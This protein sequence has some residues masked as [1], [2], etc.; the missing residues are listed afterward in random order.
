[1]VLAGI[2][3]TAWR[4]PDGTPCLVAARTGAAWPCAAADGY[5]H[6]P[7]GED[8]GPFAPPAPALSGPHTTAFVDG[9]VRAR[10]AD[11][12]ENILDTT[13]TSVVHQ[14]YLRR[15]ADRRPVEAHTASGPGWIAAT[16]PPGA[17]PGGW[18]A[19]LIG[20]H[21]YTIRDR[22]TAP[23]IAEV[24]YTDQSRPVFCAR[25]SLTPRSETETYIAGAISVPGKGPAALL[26]L[27]MLRVF[28]LR[29]FSEDRAILELI[30][31]NRGCHGNAPI[32]YTPQDLM[33]PGIDA[34]LSGRSPA[35]P[36]APVRL[37]V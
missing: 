16:Y 10:L 36:S 35:V 17:A 22:F 31:A 34:I 14:G 21:R 18:G 6:T 27:A 7:L 37:R 32:V 13:H 3:L 1:M 9:D 29:I 20:A 2:P 11:I 28:F 23:G 19:R 25:F 24:L 12:A 8:A 26:K 5:L 15:A 4:A 33:R 30:S